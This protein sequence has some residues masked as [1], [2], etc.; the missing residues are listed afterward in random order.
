[1]RSIRRSAARPAVRVW[2]LGLVVLL[3]VSRPGRAESAVNVA[4]QWNL[5]AEDIIWPKAYQ[6]EGLIYMA[7]VSAAMYDAAV[8]IEGGYEA[9]GFDV[10]CP[11]PEGKKAHR[12]R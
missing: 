7:Y 10:V 3:L 12:A 8:A 6:N 11:A 4:Q 5:I 2:L 9:Y 1:M